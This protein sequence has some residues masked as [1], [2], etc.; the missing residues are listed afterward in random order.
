MAATLAPEG[1]RRG[2]KRDLALV[3][4]VPYQPSLLRLLHGGTA[5]VVGLAWS[6]GLLLLGC[7]DGRWGRFPFQID[8]DWIEFHGHIGVVLAGV[9][10]LFVPYA[11]TL[12]AGRLRRPANSFPLLVLGL[13]VGSGLQM[14]TDWLV[15]HRITPLPYALHLTAW[16]LLAVSVPLHVIGAV[17]RGGW[18][19]AASMLSLLL[20]PLDA[21]SD[22]PGQVLRYIRRGH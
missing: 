4:A 3:M 13:A 21:P 19:L 12:G 11:L 17:R 8:G 16:L 18:P 9:L 14:Q 10:L 22:W 5:L 15:D 2:C 7:F 20:K 6:T 1:L